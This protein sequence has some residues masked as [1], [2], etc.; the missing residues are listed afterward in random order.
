MCLRIIWKACYTHT[1]GLHS[2]SFW[3]LGKKVR[4]CISTKFPCHGL[5]LY[6]ERHF[7]RHMTFP[8][9]FECQ[10]C[11][12]FKAF[13]LRH[14]ADVYPLSD[15][16]LAA[17]CHHVFREASPE[18]PCLCCSSLPRHSMSLH[19][20]LFPS[21]AFVTLW[22]YLYRFVSGVA[23]IEEIPTDPGKECTFL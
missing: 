17:S 9:L 1:A 3:F 11:F 2:W 15:L 21:W 13:A 8:L 16:G 18:H 23:V 4:M 6:L 14:L 7:L 22:N 19:L 20:V 5:G 12:Y 10:S